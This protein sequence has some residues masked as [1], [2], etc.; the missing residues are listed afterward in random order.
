MLRLARNIFGRLFKGACTP[1]SRAAAEL[2]GMGPR[3]LCDLGI[4]ASEIPYALDGGCRGRQAPDA[5]T[6]GTA[7]SIAPTTKDAEPWRIP[8]GHTD[9]DRNRKHSNPKL[10]ILG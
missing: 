10:A 9:A 8:F 7:W 5:F 3:E 2:S 6:P 4:G 1:G